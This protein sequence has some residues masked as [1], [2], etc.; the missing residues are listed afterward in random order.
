[1]DYLVADEWAQTTDDI[2]WR[3]TKMGLLLNKDQVETLRQYLSAE[4]FNS[5]LQ[6]AG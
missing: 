4:S 6:Q 2:L 1:V 5:E 3:R